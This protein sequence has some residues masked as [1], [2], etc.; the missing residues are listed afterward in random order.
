MNKEKFRANRKKLDI[1]QRQLADI[2]CL[3]A[4]NGRHYI[5]MIETGKKPPSAPLV[6]FYEL[7]IEMLKIK[8]LLEK[9][10]EIAFDCVELNMGNYDES[11]E[12]NYD[13]SQVDELNNKM[14][15]V[16]KLLSSY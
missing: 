6:G 3:S 16:C 13:E 4:K 11:Q 12:G 14:I 2:L 5:R 8:A 7:H 15:E 10:K 1:T 9:V